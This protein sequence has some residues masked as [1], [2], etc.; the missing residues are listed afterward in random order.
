MSTM[1]RSRLPGARERVSSRVG[2]LVRGRW[3][4]AAA[5]FGAACLLICLLSWPLLFTSSGLEGD[6]EHHLW[7]IW[8]QSLAIDANHAPSFFTNTSYFSFYP[9]FAFYGGTLY[10]LAGTLSLALD[11]S[12]LTAYILTYLLGFAAA[13]GGWYWLARDLGLSRWPAHVPGLIFLTSAYYLTLIYGRGDWPEFIALSS[14]P[15]MSAAGLSILRGRPLRTL[16]AATFA[17]CAIVFF[18]S[19]DITMLW[20]ST[21]FAL[22][23]IVLIACVPELRRRIRLRRA[24]L[25]AALV[26]AALMV[27]AWYLLPA[28][29]YSSHTQIGSEITQAHELLSQSMHFVSFGHL[30][31][32]SRAST[33]IA[34]RSIV[35]TVPAPAIVWVLAST[36]VVLASA[37]KGPWPR[38]LLVL[39]LV[40]AAIGVLMTHAGLLL[41]LPGP[42]TLLQYSYR[43]EGFISL[44]VSAAATVILVLARSGSKRVRLWAWTIVP[45]LIVSTVGAVAQVNG[46]PH[47]PYPREEV[48]SE[49]SEQFGEID[50]DY[51]YVPLSP[52][53]QQN[54]NELNIL[55]RQIH[56]DRASISITAHPG[57]WLITNIGG[58]PNLLHISGA[59]IIGADERNQL[60]LEVPLNARPGPNYHISITPAQTLPVVLG[61]WLTL[62]GVAALAIGLLALSLNHRRRS[63]AHS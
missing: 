10:A 17:A 32:L 18:G 15:L 27:N 16:P 3:I 59:V 39:V 34:Y 9:Q 7:F 52:I 37:R 28:L 36:L 40:T 63:I 55:P 62:L 12:P 6:W 33:A 31:T 2:P 22:A 60:V 19:H 11:N 53:L 26:G 20:G 21:L 43:L 45:V 14:L 42:Y 30:F 4:G 46:Y 13:Y 41:A 56:D 48:F 50:S 44:G 35:L 47:T 29:A 58:G 61:R 54:L 49:F 1:P 23:S 51:T 8:Q 25:A 57:E 5:A 24:L 38:V